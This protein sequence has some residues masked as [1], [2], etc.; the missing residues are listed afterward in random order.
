[1]PGGLEGGLSTLSRLT[2]DGR[3]DTEDERALEDEAEASAMRRPRLRTSPSSRCWT[4][5]YSSCFKKRWKS[6]SR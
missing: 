1:M 5:S 6:S 2:E 3:E 4:L